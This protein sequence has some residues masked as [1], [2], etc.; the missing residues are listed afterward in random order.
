M[1]I[2]LIYNTHFT[3]F[4]SSK[5]NRISRKLQGI[6]LICV[7]NTLNLRISFIYTN[8]SFSNINM[9][10]REDYKRN[11]IKEKGN[12]YCHHNMA[13]DYNTGR[14]VHLSANY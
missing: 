3:E 6:F 10:I 8:F 4:N 7:V 1:C 9:S 5:I 12:R 13:M 2:G 11:N 14:Y